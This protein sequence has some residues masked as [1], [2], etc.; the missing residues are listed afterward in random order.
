ML[1]SARYYSKE[2]VLFL[3]NV[4]RE[5]SRFKNQRIFKN[6]LWL[7]VRFMHQNDRFILRYSPFKGPITLAVIFIILSDFE[8][9]CI[10]IAGIL[11]NY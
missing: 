2:T 3:F 7:S 9:E 6:R 10:L 4:E 11:K 5:S 8:N 1:P